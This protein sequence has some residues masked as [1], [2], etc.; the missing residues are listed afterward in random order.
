MILRWAGVAHNDLV[1]QKLENCESL[2]ESNE[3]VSKDAR[4]KLLEQLQELKASF[5]AR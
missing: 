2:L 5:A 1:Q 3:A 4:E